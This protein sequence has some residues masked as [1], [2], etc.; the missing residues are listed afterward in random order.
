[1]GIDKIAFTGSTAAGGRIAAI[2]GEQLKR[3][4][5]E[6]GGKSAS[7]V[8]E[9]A[10]LDVTVEGLRMASLVNNGESC[11]AHTRILA[12]RSRYSRRSPPKPGSLSRGPSARC[13]R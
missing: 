7:I 10:D 8:L 2:A 13:T 3:V 12:P 5:L 9:D 6:L 4:S 11:V 1:M